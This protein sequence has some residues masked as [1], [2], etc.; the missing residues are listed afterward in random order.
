M[1]SPY[2]YARHT[3]DYLAPI[4][5]RHWLGTD[6]SGYDVMTRLCVGGRIS[7][8]VGVGVETI[9][10]FIGGLVGLLAGYY[11]RGVDT[12]LMRLTDIMF[13]FP[14][15]LLAIL[16]MAVRGPSLINLFIA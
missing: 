13:A 4:S 6:D 15:V 9:I 14:D 10:L 2:S 12:A 5:W 16:I 11:G 3:E 1:G 8:F 7:L